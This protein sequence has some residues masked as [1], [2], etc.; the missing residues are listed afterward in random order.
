MRFIFKHNQPFF[1]FSVYFYRNND[2][3]G[4]DLFRNVQIVKFTFRT[5]FFHT[6]NSDI[7]QCYR[8]LGIL[9][10]NSVTGSH[11]LIE[12]RLNRFIILAGFNFNI[13][14]LRHKSRM[15]AVI[16]PISI[17]YF[18]FGNSRFT[19][20]FIKIFLTP[21]HI[22]QAHCQ[23][24]FLAQRFHF[25]A[26]LGQKTG[27]RLNPGRFFTGRDQSSRFL[28]LCFSGFNRIDTVAFD[29]SEFCFGQISF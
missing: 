2:R 1:C 25:I 20:F 4:I 27:N 14:Y 9:S 18:Y 15:T 7:H 28:P 6:D 24:H 23:S 3:A 29:F 21:H 17:K 11:I 10:V 5:Q 8:A 16:G 12:S 19:V 22:F 13:F 26:V